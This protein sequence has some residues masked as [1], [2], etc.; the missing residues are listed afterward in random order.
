M[1]AL[2]SLCVR[3]GTF[4]DI[5]DGYW[6]GDGTRVQA[7]PGITEFGLLCSLEHQLELHD[8]DVLD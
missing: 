4:P 6:P 2:Y 5:T 7:E 1:I 3:M 8:P